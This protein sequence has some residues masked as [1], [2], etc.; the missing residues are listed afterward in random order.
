MSRSSSPE[1]AIFVIHQLCPPHLRQLVKDA[2]ES[3]D[4]AW[5]LPPL[6][7]ELFN[8]RKAYLA[9]LQD[10]ALSR[11]FAVVTTNLR[12]GRFRFSYIHRGEEIKNWRK[13]KQHVKKDS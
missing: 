2:V 12:V 10:F 7:V 9:R 3:F 1:H 4:N 6:E 8:S 5:L 11:G 13:L